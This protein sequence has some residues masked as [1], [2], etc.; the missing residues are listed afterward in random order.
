MEVLVV[1]APHD[2]RDEEYLIPKKILEAA[3]SKVTVAG[4]VEGV[5]TGMLGS[6]VK[7]DLTFSQVRPLDYDA[8]MLVGGAGSRK[9]LWDNKLLH[10]IVFQAWE[11]GRLVAA[12]CLSPSVLAR[13][14]ILSGVKATVFRLPA[15]TD[16]LREAGALLRDDHIVLDGNILTCDGPESAGEFAE[17]MLE[18]LS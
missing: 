16:A 8:I 10:N 15:A 9:W 3:G 1:L 17:K 12:I 14:G 7:P 18:I 11:A 4:P 13:A 2:Y 6:K 5:Y